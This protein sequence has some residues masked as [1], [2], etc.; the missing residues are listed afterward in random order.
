[1]LVLVLVLI[2]ILGLV[3]RRWNMLGWWDSI[4][5]RPNVLGCVLLLLVRVRVLLLLVGLVVLVIVLS[6]LNLGRRRVR[7]VLR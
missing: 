3:L 4:V 7:R 2:R 1:L 6:L 5:E